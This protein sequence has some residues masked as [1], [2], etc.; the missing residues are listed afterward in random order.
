MSAKTIII[1]GASRGLGAAIARAAAELGAAVVLNARSAEALEA[2]AGQIAAAGGTAL[3]VPGDVSRDD[4]CERL[5]DA[6]VS[7]FGRLDALVN[8][9]GILEPIAPIAEAD[10]QAWQRS[11]AVNVLGPVLMT[12]A[13]LPHLRE[14]GGRIVHISSGAANRPVVGWGA[15]CT[16]KAALNHLNRVLALE[17]PTLTTIAVRPGAVDTPMQGVLREKGAAGMTPEEHARFIRRYEE[18]DLLPPELPGRAIAVL[19]LH[20]PH[21]WSGEFLSWDDDAVQALVREATAAR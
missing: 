14:S 21:E 5:V 4:D 16:T 10:P 19:A 13:A 20:A 12:R 9:A 6:A 15:Y 8:N 2:A 18:G 1:T 17:E 7:R 3:A 11:W